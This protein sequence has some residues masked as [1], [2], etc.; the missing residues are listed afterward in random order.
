MIT[1]GKI[2]PTAM[3]SI[4]FLM[5]FTVGGL[6][7]ADTTITGEVDDQYQ[8]YSTDGD[9]Y[10]IA[11]TETGTQLATEH[12]N[13]MVEVVGQVDYSEEDDMKVITVKKYKIIPQDDMIEDEE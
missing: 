7:A 11:D 1:K 2:L 9:I 13:E 8:I 3:I 10:V 4:L 6:F 5:V 12:I